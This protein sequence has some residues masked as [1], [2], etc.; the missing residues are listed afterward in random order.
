[1][2]AALIGVAEYIEHYAE[3]TLSSA[4]MVP[5]GFEVIIGSLTFT[6]SLMAAAKLQELLPG[7]PITYKFQN[8]SNLALLAVLIAS[9]VV[10]IV[11]PATSLLFALLVLLSLVFGFLLV[12]PIG[13]V[14][15]AVVIFV[16][17]LLVGLADSAF[18]VVFIYM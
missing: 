13:A 11:W 14:D 1:L 15:M 8:V 3:G 4:G 9:F 16:L 6:G 5:L 2:A 7:A 18:E 12:V 17:Y 10:L